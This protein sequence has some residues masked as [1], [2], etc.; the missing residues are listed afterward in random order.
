MGKEMTEEQK[1]RSA[2]KIAIWT[3]ILVLVGI[4][5]AFFFASSVLQKTASRQFDA[6]I[7]NVVKDADVTHG[8]MD[9]DLLHGS[10]TIKDIVAVP[11]NG[12]PTARI[13][14]LTLGDFDTKNEFPHKLSVKVVGMRPDL[15]A[16]AIKRI[17]PTGN[18]QVPRFNIDFSYR[19]AA[20]SKELHL[21]RLMVNMN[22]TANITMEAIFADIDINNIKEQLYYT[23]KIPIKHVKAVIQDLG[24]FE[25]VVNTTA[26]HNNKTPEEVRKGMVDSFSFL[27]TT[28]TKGDTELA[29]SVKSIA[30]FIEAPGS[31]TVILS[32]DTPTSAEEAM[33][34]RS[35]IEGIKKFNPTVSYSK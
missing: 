13:D 10:V 28:L 34:T 26:K 1:N 12:G 24:F 27:A 22:E 4:V 9:V 14:S 3:G 15:D 31:L 16:E 6:Y 18:G 30:S 7:K 29:D 23:G 19:Y 35:P 33:M 32:P 2:K 8:S 25:E 21:D 17:D 5:G 20:I 11:R